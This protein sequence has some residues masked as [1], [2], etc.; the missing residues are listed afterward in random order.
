MSHLI[1]HIGLHKTGTSS[2]QE[3]CFARANDLA[4]AGLIYPRLNS[5]AHPAGVP[6]HHGL[7][8][9]LARFFP[10]Y[11]PDGGSKAAW[12]RIAAAHSRNTVL[13]S[14]EEFSRGRV[15][16]RVNMARLAEIATAWDKVT[17]VC[18]LRE[19]VSFLQ[20]IFL[21]MSGMGKLL[22][23]EALIA[24]IQR[25]DSAGL[26]TDWRPL[27]DHLLTGF[28]PDQ[29]HFIDYHKARAEPG[30][31]VGQILTLGGITY[32]PGRANKD[33]NVSA[34]PLAQALCLRHFAG[35]KIP[36]E[37]VG[38]VQAALEARFGAARPT[39]IFTRQEVALIRAHF[40]AP[41]AELVAR[42]R[43][44]QPD[45]ALSSPVL[46]ADMIYREDA[47]PYVDA[48]MAEAGIGSTSA[49]A[50]L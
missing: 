4:R 29:L 3:T 21:Q 24:S 42:I 26:W 43:E 6:G 12:A 38:R 15:H 17:V 33:V 47:A 18:V 40:K 41:N 25:N 9:N 39:T 48:L 20:S 14:S 45:F 5:A 49:K 44:Q 36:G 23:L 37:V 35:E 28:D 8:L 32:R 7:T 19:Q 10:Q 16:A 27:L 34:P 22:R 30:G 31:V 13:V 46:A 11:Q 2:L 1:L 50:R